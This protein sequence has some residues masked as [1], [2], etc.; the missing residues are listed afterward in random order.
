MPLIILIKS[1]YLLRMTELHLRHFPSGSALDNSVSMLKVERLQVWV[2]ASRPQ[3]PGFFS[4]L[5]T[6]ILI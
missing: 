3:S 4:P 6:L 1:N 5:L 2:V